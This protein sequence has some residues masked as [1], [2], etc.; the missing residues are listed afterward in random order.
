MS[1]TAIQVGD[2]R[3]SDLPI[4]SYSSMPPTPPGLTWREKLAYLTAKFLEL[5]QVDMPVHHSFQGDEYV[6]T[7]FIPAATLLIGRTHLKGHLCRL[8]SGELLRHDDGLTQHHK[9]GEELFTHPGYQMCVSAITGCTVQTVHPNPDG[10][11]DVDKLE[12]LWFEDKADLIALGHEVMGRLALP[13][14]AA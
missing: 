5:P 11:H 2:Q 6:R 10:L 8:L 13:E 4:H 7:M 9:S 12:A 3:Y 1:D 14:A